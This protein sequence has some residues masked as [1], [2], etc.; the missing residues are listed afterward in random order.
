MA[1]LVATNNVHE[2]RAYNTAS[3]LA[4]CQLLA[5]LQDD[6]D[7]G[8][9]PTWLSR[10][11]AVMDTRPAM[12]LLG[13]HRGRLDCRRGGLPAP[14]DTK[15]R[16]ADGLKFGTGHT[17]IPTIDPI[18]NQAFMFAYKVSGVAAHE[19]RCTQPSV[20]HSFHMCLCWNLALPCPP[21]FN[22]CLPH[23]TPALSA[24]RTML[25]VEPSI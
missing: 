11:K 15:R 22:I 7:P 9:D 12:G 14:M 16:Q 24:F 19:R 3:R 10:G 23:L 17:P 2:I 1:L 21:N 18:T 13:G 5:L 6:D 25:C 20:P 4:H 8:A